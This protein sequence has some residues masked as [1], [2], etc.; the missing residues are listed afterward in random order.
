M[1]VKEPVAAAYATPNPVVPHLR[2]Y[3]VDKVEAETDEDVLERILAIVSP[4]EASFKQRFNQAKT[5]TEK[6]CTPEVAAA[7]E[8]EGF[9]INKPRPFEDEPF[10]VDAAI[11]DDERDD[12]APREWL[13]KM[14]PEVY[15]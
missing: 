9:M 15:A 13:E 4:H 8:A 3:I 11:R 5:Q 6:Y 10:D 1:E 14:F 7:L 2:H 12:N